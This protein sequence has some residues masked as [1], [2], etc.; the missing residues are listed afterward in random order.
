[1]RVWIKLI[2]GSVFGL[3]LGF[4][5]PE[6]HPVVTNMFAFLQKLAIGIG[7]YTA[8]PV[9]VFSLTIGIYE[10]RQDG[11]FWSLLVRA[12]LLL[13]GVSVFVIALG[14]G[15]TLFFPPGRIPVLIEQQSGELLFS[16]AQNV[17]DIFSP[18]MLSVLFTDGVYIFPLCVFAFF[19]ASGL[20]YD[21]NYTKPVLSLI[22]SL[23][24]IFFHIAAFFSEMLGLL[25]IVLSAYWALQYREVI[26]T[27]VFVSVMRMLLLYSAVLVFVV[28]PAL[29]FFIKRAP[30]KALYGCL[31]PAIAAFFS[32]DYN[33]SVPVLT[34]HMKNNLGIR[35]RSG[36]VTFALFSTFGRSGSAMVA[37]VAFIVI[38]KSY[39]SLGIPG[40]GILNIGITAFF[41]SFLLARNS[42]DAAFT[43][44]AVLCMRYGHGFE[45]GY[46]I[47]KPIAF[48]LIS[49]GTFIDI[50]INALGS[51][52]IAGISGFQEEKS[53]KRFI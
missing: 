31:G 3:L 49:I 43:A 33:F 48:Y 37:C 32:G 10:L 20:R 2:I 12:V 34:T 35:R 45:T 42:S 15:V 36:S 22:D 23:S 44:L 25:I 17:L 13:S 8:L 38:I 28:L 18:N 30:W 6:N 40:S 5:L 24:R 4:L 50:V 21:R 39:S 19:L 41:L 9:I 52:T 27:G 26:G 7:R 11:K 51:F 14:I 1:M 29:L 16:P 53:V 47:L 46:L